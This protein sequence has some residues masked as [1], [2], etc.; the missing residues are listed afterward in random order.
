M[1]MVDLKDLSVEANQV[2]R[3]KAV[4]EREGILAAKNL[5][6]AEVVRSVADFLRHAVAE[7]D[8]TVRPY[9]FSL[10]DAD[11]P[12]RLTALMENPEARIS[13]HDRHMF[14]GH[15]PLEVRLAE[16]LRAIPRFLNSHPLLFE[17]LSSQRL[18]AHMPP[19]A[20]YVLP[21]CSLA[22]VPLHQDISYNRHIGDFCVVWVPLVPIDLACG[23][24]AAYARTHHAPEL[25]AEHKNAAAGWL[26][27]I[28]SGSADGAQR[29][30]LAP[31]VPGDVVIM[32]K[33]TMHESMPNSSD[34]M[35]LSCDFRFFGEQSHSTKH[36]LDIAANTVVAPA[37]AQ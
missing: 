1:W 11:A 26:A 14:L 33:R 10:Q 24:M 32:G 23:G 2:D 19:T 9:G 28:D 30:V 5:L 8:K 20:R 36:Y 25:I 3:A 17:L 37:A 34:R 29:V 4:F 13:E 12:E 31:L 21:R 16:P 22:R 27:P 15:F 35:R 7:I 6:A 18:Y